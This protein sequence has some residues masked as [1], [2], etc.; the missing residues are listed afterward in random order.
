MKPE[1]V[2][3]LYWFALC[4]LTL[5]VV[6]LLTHNLAAFFTLAALAA[7]LFGIVGWKVSDA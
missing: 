7:I 2:R 6:G 3:W 5:G 4:V 1:H